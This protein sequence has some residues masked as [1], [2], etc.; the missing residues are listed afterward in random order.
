MKQV[1]QV[2]LLPVGRPTHQLVTGENK[3]ATART[4]AHPEHSPA[5]VRTRTHHCWGPVGKTQNQPSLPPATFTEC[6]LCAGALW[7]AAVT[8]PTVPWPCSPGA[9]KSG[10]EDT[11]ANRTGQR[12]TLALG[13]QGRLPRNSPEADTEGWT[14]VRA[15]ARAG[16]PLRCTTRTHVMFK[17][18][19]Q[20][21]STHNK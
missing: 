1:A 15:S 5:C 3:P 4:A 10:R 7:Q 11:R 20:I 9:L 14:G 16:F 13:G 18:E 19:A 2:K 8:Q 6:L 17:A 12:E 21:Q